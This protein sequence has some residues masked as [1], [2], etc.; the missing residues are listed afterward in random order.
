MWAAYAGMVATPTQEP[1]FEIADVQIVSEQEFVAAT[2]PAPTVP[3]APVA[4]ARLEAETFSMIA[5]DLESPESL[6]PLALDPEGLSL[7]QLEAAE[8]VPVPAAE[9]QFDSEVLVLSALQ[10]SEPF[11]PAVP[12]FDAP[13]PALSELDVSLP[14]D[15]LPALQAAPRIADRVA[16]EPEPDAIEA[17]EVQVASRP[18]PT[19]DAEASEI[20][21]QTTAPAHT[22]DRIVTEAEERD[23]PL[24]V[25]RP[26]RRPTQLARASQTDSKLEEAEQE[27]PAANVAAMIEQV[28]QNEADEIVANVIAATKR[29]EDQ[30]EIGQPLTPTEGQRLVAQVQ[31]CWNLGATSTEA[32]RTTVTIA[33]SMTDEGK[34]IQGSVKLVRSNSDSERAVQR[35]FE[36][37]RHAIL[38]CLENGHDLPIEKYEQWQNVEM[39][40]DPREMM[41]K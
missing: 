8:A 19:A 17:D 13:E 25:Q 23:G 4:P 22:S 41:R 31:S 11:V 39:T 1:A 26:R 3:S 40:F 12:D 38:K 20:V 15:E 21:D 2:T 34:P 32:L 10:A 28:E 33:F 35:A 9:T 29:P 18:D 7:P 14:F 27:Q 6:T 16:P 36:S 5:P 24:A 37:G 30:P